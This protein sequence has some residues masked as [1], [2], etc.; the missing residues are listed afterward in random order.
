MI[1]VDVPLKAVTSFNWGCSPLD[2]QY[3]SYGV[4]LKSSQKM[5]GYLPPP[6][7]PQNI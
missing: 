6:E 1:V 3:Y 4:G 7:P 2:L 5:V